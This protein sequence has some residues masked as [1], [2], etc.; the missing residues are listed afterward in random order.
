MN[1]LQQ[2]PISPMEILDISITAGLSGGLVEIIWIALYGQLAHV[3]SADVARQMTFTLFAEP[4]FSAYPAVF[5]VLIHLVLSVMLSGVFVG[6]THSA[7]ASKFGLSANIKNAVLLLLGIWV[8]NFFVLLPCHWITHSVLVVLV[9]LVGLFGGFLFKGMQDG[10]ETASPVSTGTI[11]GR[12]C[13][14][15][16]QSQRAHDLGQ[17]GIPALMRLWAR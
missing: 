1:T 15:G 17:S 6:L 11:E 12:Q 7:L 4:F 14:F 13:H 9:F 10:R 8:L 16:C 5:G 3:S 2:R